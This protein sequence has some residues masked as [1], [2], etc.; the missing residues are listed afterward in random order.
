MSWLLSFACLFVVMVAR[1]DQVT[2]EWTTQLSCTASER[3]IE[4]GILAFH[5]ALGKIVVG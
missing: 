1:I 2:Y 3:I 5:V 4:V